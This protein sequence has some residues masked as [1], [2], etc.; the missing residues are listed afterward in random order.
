MS[1]LEKKLELLTLTKFVRNKSGIN[2]RDLPLRETKKEC[3][4]DIKVTNREHLTYSQYRIEKKLDGNVFSFGYDSDIIYDIKLNLLSEIKT[5]NVKIQIGDLI[6]Y[7]GPYID[8][9]FNIFEDFYP[10]TYL[11]NIL[12][13]YIDG[14]VDLSISYTV[15][16][17]FN[18]KVGNDVD[19]NLVLFSKLNNEKYNIQK[20]K[21]KN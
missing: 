7:D 21:I 12:K 13:I 9:I 17:F 20:L 19:E 11:N 6:I 16:Y 4:H 3:I 18:N 1:T 5:F 14:D 2:L 15:G 8:T 10:T